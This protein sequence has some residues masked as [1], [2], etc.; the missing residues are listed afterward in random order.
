MPKQWFDVQ[1]GG[2]WQQVEADSPEQAAE[3]AKAHPLWKA[4][5]GMGEQS[6]ADEKPYQPGIADS[7]VGFLQGIGERA[8]QTV[9]GL[10]QLPSVLY[11]DPVGTLKQMPSAMWEGVKET[12]NNLMSG[13]AR[14]AGSA[15]FDL[16]PAM[17]PAARVAGAATRAGGRA[18][19]SPLAT[20]ALKSQNSGGI[21]GM[22]KDMKGYLADKMD[23]DVYRPTAQ[24]LLES[25]D[26]APIGPQVSHVG[27]NSAT[28]YQSPIN[29]PLWQQAQEIP[30]APRG[31][32]AGVEATPYNPA[33]NRPVWQQVDEVP[34][35]P[36]GGPP[37]GM[38]ATPSRPA[39]NRPLYEQVDDLPEVDRSARPAGI[40]GREL[41][42]QRLR[43]KSEVEGAPL[44][45]KDP[46]IVPEA[47][48]TPPRASGA[49]PRGQGAPTGPKAPS[50]A[51]TADAE[52]F[53]ALLAKVEK[54]IATEQEL[55][56]FDVLNA[57]AGRTASAM[58]RF[59]A[60][61]GGR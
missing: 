41:P 60:G 20:A 6:T 16:A 23:P 50:G 56:V 17:I 3:L 21:F 13:N 47:T 27:S 29:R 28:P 38:G 14:K 43:L 18:L 19:R 26:D 37:S 5:Q 25:I 46:Y 44:K 7:A 30:D 57:R 32:P 42:P 36:R 59:H 11:N 9:E 31:A 55:Q 4:T 40:E 35:T 61:T 1:I 39:I 2:E 51:P 8:G 45:F 54:G 24:E 12:G 10:S 58:G 34:D 52:L 22:L 49:G 15:A 33:I 48:R 53:Q